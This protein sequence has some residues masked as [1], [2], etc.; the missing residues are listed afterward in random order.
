MR[1]MKTKLYKTMPNW[2]IDTTETPL[3]RIEEI[4]ATLCKAR[5]RRQ[6]K[7][8][9]LKRKKRREVRERKR[10]EGQLNT[11]SGSR[12]T[13]LQTHIKSKQQIIKEYDDRIEGLTEQITAIQTR[14]PRLE[15]IKTDIELLSDLQDD[16]SWQETVDNLLD[17]LRTEDPVEASAGSELNS[18]LS[19][20]DEMAEVGKTNADTSV[21]IP[22]PENVGVTEQNDSIT[23]EDEDGHEG[24]HTH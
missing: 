14:F 21:G 17:H 8:S 24:G 23:E 11:V 13:E 1:L 5:D 22:M 6:S 16:I 19:E 9:E 4:E 15:V 7:R 20:I 3:N 2:L 18:L 10:A 12:A